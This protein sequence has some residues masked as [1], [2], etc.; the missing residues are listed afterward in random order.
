VAVLLRMPR[1]GA[2]MEEGTL[3]TWLVAEGDAVSAGDV[4]CEIEI[5]KLSNELEAPEDG[6]LRAILCPQGETLPCGAPLA[7][8]AGGDEDISA[9]LTDLPAGAVDSGDL[10]ASGLRITPKALVL[11]EELNIDYRSIAGTG[12]LGAITREDIRAWMGGKASAKA[13]DTKKSDEL[14]KPGEL[15]KPAEAS[16]PAGAANAVKPSGS[17]IGARMSTIRKVTARRMME[18]LS[19]SAQSTIMMDA[20]ITDLVKAY[21]NVKPAYAAEGIKLSWTAIILK[22]A[23]ETLRRHPGIRT[24]IERDEI[25]TTL[26]DIDIGVAVD[27][28]YGL[29]VP[30]LRKLDT[31]PLQTICRELAVTVDRAKAGSLGPEESSGGCFSITNVGMLNVKYFTPILNAPQSAI[32][33]IGTLTEEPRILDGGLHFRWIASLSMTYDHRIV[34]GAPAARFLNDLRSLLASGT[35]L[36]SGSSP[37]SG[38]GP[39]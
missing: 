20:D 39:K 4:L 2:N 29:V 26:S 37:D 15:S 13:V 28:D 1:Y 10:P 12:I 24:I 33:G 9:L 27:V 36:D 6:V 5:E 25:L 23:A 16:E 32:L 21:T 18:S 7:V 22:A 8:L 17:R 31:K 34:D 19:G 38:R 11:A 35:I 3:A 14:S 30:V